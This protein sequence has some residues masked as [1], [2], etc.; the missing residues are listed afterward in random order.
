MQIHCMHAC[1]NK[2]D[3]LTKKIKK[4]NINPED[5][6]YLGNDVNDLDCL[7]AAGLPACVFGAHP[8]VLKYCIYKTKSKGG[9]GA[10]R[11]FCDFII[12]AKK[13]IKVPRTC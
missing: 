13:V 11:E 9:F 4:L 5:V 3:I 1:E 12:R 10:I 7:K 2:I 6:A 8:E